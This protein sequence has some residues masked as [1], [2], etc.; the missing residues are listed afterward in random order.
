MRILGAAL[1][2]VLLLAGCAPEAPVEPVESDSPVIEPAEMPDEPAQLFDGDCSAMF[3]DSALSDALG[4]ELTQLSD[5]LE[6]AFSSGQPIAPEDLL[7]EQAGGIHCM[8]GEAPSADSFIPVLVVIA[9]PAD[10]VTAAE[11]VECAPSD[12]SASGCPVDV[13]ANGIRLSGLVTSDADASQGLARVAAVEGLFEASA[14]A[15]PAAGAPAAL[16][17]QWASGVDCAGIAAAVDWA[18]LGE[19]EPLQSDDT[20]GTD[21]YS[22]VVELDLRDGR[23]V[24]PCMLYGTGSLGVSFSVLGG[25]AWNRDAVLAQDGA[26]V[27]DVPGFDFVIERAEA[28]TIDIF[29]G[30]NWLHAYDGGNAADLYPALTAIVEALDAQAS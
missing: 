24:Y 19:A 21:A 25:G 7:V 8:W 26:Q 29:D 14:S 5:E 23:R 28:G 3:A 1:V 12:M 13:T 2:G 9:V 4:Q 20:M 27:V 11:D 10:A 16:E 30:V 22:S 15:T 18:A 6:A 17:G